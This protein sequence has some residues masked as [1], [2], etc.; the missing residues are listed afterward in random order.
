MRLIMECEHGFEYSHKNDGSICAG[1]ET[2]DP[3][4]ILETLAEAGV[5]EVDRHRVSAERTLVM[6]YTPWKEAK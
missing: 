5:L 4:A 2:S 3:D 1:Y 6:Y